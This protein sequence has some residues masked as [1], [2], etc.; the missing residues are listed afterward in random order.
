MKAREGTLTLFKRWHSIGFKTDQ[1]ITR[2]DYY[3]P[4]ALR[5]INVMFL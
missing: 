5:N 4:I 2:K 1:D 3:R